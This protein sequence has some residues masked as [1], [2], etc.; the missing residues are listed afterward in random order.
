MYSELGRKKER[1]EKQQ[2]EGGERERAPEGEEE[3]EDI[4]EGS[5]AEVCITCTYGITSLF[6]CHGHL[7]R[8][9]IPCHLFPSALADFS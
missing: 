7:I 5:H 1:R 3:R 4:K 9:L 6:F 2:R 8:F